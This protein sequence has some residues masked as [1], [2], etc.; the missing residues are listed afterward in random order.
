M[1]QNVSFDKVPVF[2]F[3]VLDNL[4][5]LSFFDFF[6]GLLVFDLLELCQWNAKFE[7]LSDYIKQISLLLL[8]LALDF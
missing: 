3:L 8:N 6:S 5:I 1:L 2:K 7:L 4:F